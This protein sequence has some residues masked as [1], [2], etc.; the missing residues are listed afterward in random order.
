[1]GLYKT[2]H[3]SGQIFIQETSNDRAVTINS[4]KELRD[5][6]KS[7]SMCITPQ[8]PVNQPQHQ[9][10]HQNWSQQNQMLQQNFTQLPYRSPPKR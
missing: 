4:H 5:L 10:L 7:L 6:A 8:A 2:W 3:K 1:M 9:V